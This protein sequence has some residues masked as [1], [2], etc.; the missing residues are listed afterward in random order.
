M[1]LS[2]KNIPT[3][4]GDSFNISAGYANGA[5]R[6]VLG[7]VTGN[8]FAMYG[9]SGL[10]GVYQSLALASSSD[11]VFANGTGIEKTNAW[12]VRGAFNHNWNPN[13]VTSV[14]GA[15]TAVSYTTAGKNLICATAVGFTCNPD[16][17]ISQVGTVTGWTPVKGLTFSAEVIYTWLVQKYGGTIALPLIATKPAAVYEFKDQGTWTASIRAQRVF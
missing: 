8:T 10:P 4:P 2:I 16:F 12:G 1:A 13:W 6:Y 14:F 3:G 7:G 11:G 15:Y 5:S 17:A 9:G